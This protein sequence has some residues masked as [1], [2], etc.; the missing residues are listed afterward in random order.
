ME[1]VQ[2]QLESISV[3]LHIMMCHT[4]YG[5]LELL[6]F[7]TAPIYIRVSVVTKPQRLDVTAIPWPA[8]PP[9]PSNWLTP[10]SIRVC[11]PGP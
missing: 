4:S 9:A 2:D 7:P 11:V 1:A 8:E 3:R 5:A 10:C 6:Y